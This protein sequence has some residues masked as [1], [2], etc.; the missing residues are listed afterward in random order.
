MELLLTLG[1][2]SSAVAVRDGKVIAGYEEERHERLKSCSIFPLISAIKCIEAA[3]PTKDEDNV[4]FVSH[5]FDDY[6]FQT[7]NHQKIHEKYW[8]NDYIESLKRD[9]NFKVISL[10]KDFTHHDAHAYAVTGFYE[11]HKGGNQD[12]LILVADG[13]GNQQEVMSLY[14]L[15]YDELGMRHV[16]LFHRAYGYENSLGLFYQYATSYTGMTEN[17]DEY[18]F[19]GYESHIHEV[20]DDES[21]ALLHMEADKFSQEMIEGLEHSTK[22]PKSIDSKY[23]NVVLLNSVKE[24][25]Q[26]KFDSLLSKI[27]FVDDPENFNKRVIIGNFIQTVLEQVASHFVKKHSPGTLLVNGGIFYNVKLNNKL[28]RLSEK[29]SVIP[30]AGDQGAAI[31]MYIKNIGPFDFSNLFWGHRDIK[32]EVEK[33]DVNS[34]PENVEIYHNKESLVNRIVDLLKNNEIPQV[35]LGSMEFG[36]RALCHTT[37][38]SIP[39]KE[40][41]ELINT[42][43]K[44]NT[45]MPMAPI[46]LRHNLDYFFDEKQF[47]KTIG[48]DGFMILTYDYTINHCDLY[49]GI[50]HKYPDEDLY[51]GR[52][53]VVDLDGSTVSLILEKIQGTA[54]ALIN[55][56]YNV[57]GKPIVLSVEHA[58]DDFKYQLGRAQELGLKKPYLIIGTYQE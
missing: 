53:Q 19:L 25:Y 5:W 44:R 11:F 42:Y 40:N 12:A 37:T 18:K 46:M 58:I 50:M 7:N 39:Y 56:S 1:H 34:L 23:V 27:K 3:K 13:F 48:S 21:Y 47:N 32:G 20:I 43:N 52:P 49:S 31:G 29:F 35:V 17:Q 6:D 4:I 28:E 24:K 8:N 33:L 55:T 45:V 54:K 26:K 30:L 2:N 16:D 38:Y 57:H 14:G 41:V 10:S 22:I 9:Y 51:S 36:P 15:T